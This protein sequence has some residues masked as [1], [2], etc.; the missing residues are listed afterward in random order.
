LAA[1][2]VAHTVTQLVLVLQVVVHLQEMLVL[3]HL[4][5]A[6]T[7]ARR[8]VLLMDGLEAAGVEKLMLA[9]LVLQ[10]TALLLAEQ[11]ARELTTLQT[12]LLLVVAV[13]VL[14]LL[15]VQVAAEMVVPCLEQTR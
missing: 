13:V 10:T 3:E 1:A 4:A 12:L 6:Q 8:V 14:E 9:V 5:K 7:V 15:A 2:E 11:A